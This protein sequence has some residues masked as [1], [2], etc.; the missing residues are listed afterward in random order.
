MPLPPRSK[1]AAVTSAG[2]P[3]P[4]QYC[5]ACTRTVNTEQPADPGCAAAPWCRKKVAQ[6]AAAENSALT[7]E[8]KQNS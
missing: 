8:Q 5:S 4:L 7:S 1:A 6:A 3:N 2:K